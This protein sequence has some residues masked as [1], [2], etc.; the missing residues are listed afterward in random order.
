MDINDLIALFLYGAETAA[1]VT[2]IAVGALLVV[3]AA[4]APIVAVVVVAVLRARKK[5]SR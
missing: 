3:A 1:L 5:R 2:A 4:A